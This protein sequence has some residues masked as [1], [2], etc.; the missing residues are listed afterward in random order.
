VTSGSTS[1]P[2]YDS[3]ATTRGELAARKMTGQITKRDKGRKGRRWIE[4]HE[5]AE[6]AWPTPL[7]ALLIAER[8]SA[9]SGHDTDFVMLVTIAYTS[10]RPF[11][12]ELLAGHIAAL[13]G[14]K[15]TCRKLEAPWCQGASYVFLG[16]G[17][18]HFR[19][20]DYGA[21]YFR[22]SA[23]GRYPKRGQRPAMPVLADASCCFPGRPVGP[24]P[25]AI[26]GEPFVVPVGRGV[27]RLASDDRT[28][29]CPSCGRAFRRR[30][31]G[32][33][34]VHHASD[35]LVRAP[36]NLLPTI[37]PSAPGCRSRAGWRRTACG[38][39]TADRPLFSGELVAGAAAALD[40]AV[41]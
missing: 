34:I 41:G 18:G 19:R 12:A 7:E 9:L 8:C 38:T 28:G 14:R 22:P 1:T 2:R 29:R 35:R 11:L 31:D 6:K 37:P 24:W 13:I 16:P 21:R 36:G 40:P 4:R 10:M 33:L 26:V 27:P 23:D 39:G 17:R 20:S 32:M 15:C 30:L 3:L 25:A 5:R